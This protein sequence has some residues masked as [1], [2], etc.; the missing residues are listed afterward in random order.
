MEGKTAAAALEELLASGVDA[1]KAETLA[2]HKMIP[3]N[4]PSNTFLLSSLTPH[5]LGFLT[6]LYE[7]AVYVQSVLW[8]INAFDQWGVE[9][10]KVL[11]TPIYS[12]LGS[13]EAVPGFDASTSN[14]ISVTRNLQ[15]K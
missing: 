2:P 6:S 10:G 4:R 14:L 9:L 15:K 8:H 3:G 1:S 5:N 12:A 13:S 11:S 7:N